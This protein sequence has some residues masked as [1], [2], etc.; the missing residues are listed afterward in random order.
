FPILC[1]PLEI[2]DISKCLGPAMP[3]SGRPTE[4]AIQQPPDSLAA[5]ALP[6][7]LQGF[8][9]QH[10]PLQR[11]ALLVRNDQPCRAGSGVTSLRRTYSAECSGQARA[12]SLGWRTGA[13]G[14]TQTWP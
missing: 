1:I 14:V 11:L 12:P 9:A 2:Y 7:G 13:A 10:L 6:Q 5:G 8:A 4:Q 3:A